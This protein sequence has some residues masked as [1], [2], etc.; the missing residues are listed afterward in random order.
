MLA[1]IE[2]DTTSLDN[3]TFPEVVKVSEETGSAQTVIPAALLMERGAL[4]ISCML[5]KI[6]LSICLSQ[7][8]DGNVTAVNILFSNLE[9]FLPKTNLEMYY[10]QYLVM[11]C[12]VSLYVYTGTQPDQYHRLF[13]VKSSPM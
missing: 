13:L 10:Q 3:I 11:F 6:C 2:V 7:F 9:D 12:S 8:S 5:T 1:A 4:G